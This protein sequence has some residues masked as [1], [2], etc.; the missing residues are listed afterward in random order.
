M[1]TEKDLRDEFASTAM[2]ALYPLFAMRGATFKMAAFMSDEDGTSGQSSI[3][4]G[5]VNYDALAHEAYMLADAM[6][7][8]RNSSFK[9]ALDAV[10]KEAS[11][12]RG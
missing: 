3:E 11:E 9:A 10:V 7:R 2:L 5:E 8:A 12:H 1:K 4:G 6:M